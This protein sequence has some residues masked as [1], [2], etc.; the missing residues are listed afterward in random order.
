MIMNEFKY[1]QH[2]KSFTKIIL[3]KSSQT[4]NT[5]MFHLYK[6]QKEAKYNLHN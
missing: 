1:M 3:S 4:L 2:E 5:A 6:V